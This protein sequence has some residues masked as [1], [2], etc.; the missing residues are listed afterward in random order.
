[1]A[2]NMVFSSITIHPK[3]AQRPIIPIDLQFFNVTARIASKAKPG[4]LHRDLTIS[5]SLGII[6]PTSLPRGQ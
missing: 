2:L 3:N 4:N 5:R 6:I 1:M